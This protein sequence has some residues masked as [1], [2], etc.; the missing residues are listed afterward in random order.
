[1]PI[2]STTAG[3]GEEEENVRA[4]GAGVSEDSRAAA[5]GKA[6]A[7]RK[8]GGEV[9][10]ERASL[11]LRERR[12]RRDTVSNTSQG[13]HQPS[14]AKALGD[15]LDYSRRR[16]NCAVDASRRGTDFPIDSRQRLLV[17]EN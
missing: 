14:L 17:N 10:L 15:S 1:M 5:E 13:P 2:S 12:C 8:M 9:G 16:R 6:V 4:R 11:T 3:D 7:A